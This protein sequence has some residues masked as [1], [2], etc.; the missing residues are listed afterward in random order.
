MMFS[1]RLL[2]LDS[3]LQDLKMCGRPKKKKKVEAQR[4]VVLWPWEVS[5]SVP[6]LSTLVQLQLLTSSNE[7]QTWKT[8]LGYSTPCTTVENLPWLLF[9]LWLLSVVVLMCGHLLNST[10]PPLLP[11]SDWKSSGFRWWNENPQTAKGTL[12]LICHHQAEGPWLGRQGR[13]FM[14]TSSGGKCISVSSQLDSKRWNIPVTRKHS[15]RND[16]SAEFTVSCSLS[17]RHSEAPAWF[18][19]LFTAQWEDILTVSQ[20]D[21]KTNVLLVKLNAL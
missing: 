20:K 5:D 9:T 6:H 10:P 3:Q 7:A 12:R 19:E 18:I 4:D 14:V 21:I 1:L 11:C 16:C 15:K 13:W 8:F 2:W 17:F